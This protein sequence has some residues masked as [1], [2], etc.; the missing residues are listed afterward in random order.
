MWW[1]VQQNFTKFEIEIIVLRF[2][3]KCSCPSLLQCALQDTV[4]GHAR[5]NSC[6]TQICCA[7]CNK[8]PYWCQ[9]LLPPPAESWGVSMHC[10]TQLLGVTIPAQLISA[11]PRQPSPAMPRAPSNTYPF[12]LTALLPQAAMCGDPSSQV[13]QLF[14]HNFVSHF[15]WPNWL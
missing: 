12:C 11:P 2:H 10:R 14:L 4:A 13:M 3:E 6:K 7:L 5:G 1:I 9:T 15:F 8:V